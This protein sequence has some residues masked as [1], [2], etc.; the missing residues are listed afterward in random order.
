M[1]VTHADRDI[2]FIELRER[3]DAWI[4]EHQ[5][6]KCN[7]MSCEH[8]AIAIASEFGFDT[9]EVNEDGENGARWSGLGDVN[10]D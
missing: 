2:E 1:Q 6:G 9:V 3:V 5:H 4:A 7:T 10:E 8:W